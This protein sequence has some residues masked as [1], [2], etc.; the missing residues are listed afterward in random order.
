[1]AYFAALSGSLDFRYIAI[2]GPVGAG[3]SALADRLGARLDATVVLDETDNPFLADFYR[4]RPGAAFQAQLFFTL[5]RHRQQT[6]LRQSDLFSQLT[7]SDYLFE[8]DKI[9]AYLNLDDNELFIYQR[10]YELLATDVR[11]P[12][13]VVYL[14]APTEVLRRR[15][16]ERAKTNPE[17]RALDDEY[18]REL[19]EAYTHFFFHYSATP[20]L[21]VETSQFDLSWGEEA[22]TDLERQVRTMG[23][24]TR[25]YVART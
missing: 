7:V 1:V 24:G 15:L 25:Y 22:L 19:N 8:R 18:I 4:D 21:V 16:R 9:Y 23:K 13:L 11:A 3:K 2:E 20:L 17:L 5:S 14:Q 10:L 12:D 6:A